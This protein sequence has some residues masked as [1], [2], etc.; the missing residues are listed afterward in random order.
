MFAE[1]IDCQQRAG[2]GA[3]QQ[4]CETGGNHPP[5]GDKGRGSLFFL[6]LLAER[7][8]QIIHRHESLANHS[9]SLTR[10]RLKGNRPWIGFADSDDS[11]Q[12]G[13]AQGRPANF[14]FL[15]EV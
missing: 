4:H 3:Q 12:N 15:Q 2:P 11:K 7:G 8:V 9:R 10:R 13:A 5:T 6:D 1:R 14:D